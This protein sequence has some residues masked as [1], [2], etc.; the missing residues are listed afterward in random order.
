MII[1]TDGG[2]TKCDWIVVDNNGEQI[3]EKIRTKGL[4][5]AIL[6]GKKLKKIIRKSDELMT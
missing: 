1:I 4:N 2:S 3:Q 5:P 6:K